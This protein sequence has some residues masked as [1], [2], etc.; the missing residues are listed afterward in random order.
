[1]EEAEEHT[2]NLL[3]LTQIPLDGSHEEYVLING[4]IR[5]HSARDIP[6]DILQLILQLYV[7]F[8][9]WHEHWKGTP[10]SV[11]D[12]LNNPYHHSILGTQTVST[13]K[14]WWS[15]KLRMSKDVSSENWTNLIG[16]VDVEAV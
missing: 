15:F 1:M 8:E 13:G 10:L 2:N 5:I 9:R 7:V 16:I 6:T 14:H 12:Y 4:Y 3:N 11:T